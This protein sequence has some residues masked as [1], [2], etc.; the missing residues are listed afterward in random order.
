MDR[1]KRDTGLRWC[2]AVALILCGAAAL[3]GWGGW[4]ATPAPAVAAGPVND[5][6]GDELATT[7]YDGPML[8]LRAAIGIHPVKGADRRQ[9]ARDLRAA[10]K[11]DGY[12]E[13]TDA[14]FAVFDKGLLET[15][16]PELTLVLPEGAS[17][18]DADRFMRDHQPATVGFYTAR[19]VLVHH[20]TFAVVP[21][22]GVTPAQA[23]AAE[24]AEGVLSDS[25]N[26]Y[27][28]TVQPAGLT[29]RYFGAVLSDGQ[30]EAV[31]QAMGRA[32]RVPAERVAVAAS[33][34]GP[35]VDLAHGMP[36][37]T[38]HGGGHH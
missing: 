17:A 20:L 38:K 9:I 8:R 30:I 4:S 15:V 21:A 32:A 1:R 29:V 10:A 33:E 34:P 13:L 36:D 16:V 11:R 12:G 3:G 25:L 7:S 2:L 23:Q 28:T 6:A 27:V 19:P 35:G 31:R 24:D 22:A 26:S 5:D 18:G 37:L 14:T